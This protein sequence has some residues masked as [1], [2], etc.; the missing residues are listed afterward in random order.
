MYYRIKAMEEN[1][2]TNTA[3]F[4]RLVDDYLIRIETESSPLRDIKKGEV[5]RLATPM[6]LHFGIIHI[7]FNMMW[8]WSLGLAI[9]STYRPL[10]FAVLVL[11]IAVISNI[12]QALISGPNF[13][14]MSGVV[15]G[16]FGF[17]VVHG[18]LNPHSGLHL[19]KRTVNFM[20][21]WLVLCFTGLVGPIA[22]WAHTFGLLTGAIMGGALAL[23]QGGW[24]TVK[25]RHEFKRAA[26]HLNTN[27][28]HECCV[29][30]KTELD[31]PY[32]D[33]RVHE[34]GNEYCVQHLKEI[35]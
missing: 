6:F 15:Y 20:L 31:D 28:L 18:K 2:N 33:F 14:G 25:R 17:I 35:D 3:E 27:A 19:D 30:G 4:N 34:D 5:W 22:N 10:K 1:G 23:K 12:A 21:I 29:C 26:S 16:L 7:L 13:G 24:Q 11:T 32:M 9:E 8:I